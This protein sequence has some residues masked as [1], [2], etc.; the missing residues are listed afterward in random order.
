MLAKLSQGHWPI[1]IL[2]CFS[3]FANLFLPIFLARTLSPEQMGHYKIFFLHLNAIPFL[4]LTGGPLHS[5]YYWVGRGE[6]DQ[7]PYLQQSYILSFILSALILVTGLPFITSLSELIKLPSEHVVYLLFGAFFA[8]PG[9]FYGQTKIA[10]GQ[11][12]K[13][14]LYDAAFE[15]FKVVC[16]VFIA[17]NSRNTGDIFLA[18]CLIFGFKFIMSFLLK[19]KDGLISLK[20]NRLKAKEIMSYCVPIS[21]AGLV[22]FFVDKMDQFVLASQLRSDEFAFYSMGCLI[23]P[24]LYLMEMSVAKVL[25]PKLSASWLNGGKDALIHF[26]K[27]VGDIS[28]LLLPACAGLFLFARP[29]IELLYTE[30]YTDSALYLK[31][32]AFSYLF[33]IVPFDA[34]PRATG[35]TNWIFKLTLIIGVFSL[36]AVLLTSKYLGAI[37]TLAA[38][39]AFKFTTRAAGLVYSAKIMNWRLLE[40]LPFKRLFIFA[41][42]SIL[43]AGGS[44]A[45]QNL[46]ESQLNWFLVCGPIFAIL[47]FP[48]VE[49]LK[50]GFPYE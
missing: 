4:F 31:V 46:F 12:I 23:I 5:I 28:Y 14:P 40:T 33:L 22:S 34:V 26:R 15:L 24:P 8:V 21:L 30:T 39:L 44:L 42:V 18:F 7:T 36:I 32:F 49:L 1:F 9:D 13:G 41:G 6:K 20:L 37:E 38:A 35:R 25:I 47:Y 17:L 10:L 2:S 27:A 19:L 45:S 29:I 3:S 43:L 50:K 11:T 48:L 16:F